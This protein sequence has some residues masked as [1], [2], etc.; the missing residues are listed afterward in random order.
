MPKDECNFT[1]KIG[2]ARWGN[3]TVFDDAKWVAD[4]N[5]K[6]YQEQLN[7]T[8]EDP[9]FAEYTFH[10]GY[11]YADIVF[12]SRY[13]GILTPTHNWTKEEI[14]R[15]NNTQ[16]IALVWQN[17]IHTRKLL[18]SELLR[19][20]IQHMKSVHESNSSE[21]DP[22]YHLYSG[23]DDQVANILT[24]ILPSF[25]YTYIPYVSNIYFEFHQ[26]NGISKVMTKFNGNEMK[27][28]GCDNTLCDY[29]QFMDHMSKVL[30]LNPEEVQKQC[31]VEPTDDDYWNTPVYVNT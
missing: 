4:L 7:L 11:K 8:E 21:S 27:L 31:A 5:K 25:N 6:A 14:R 24:Q 15:A 26:Q 10:S 3:M 17:T 29:D 12:A 18:I 13:E 19:N 30:E 9:D 22:K 23:H 2:N 28:D 16:K 20:P 1:S